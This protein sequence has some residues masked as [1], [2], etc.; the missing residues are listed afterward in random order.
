M[1]II[2][3]ISILISLIFAPLGCVNLWKKYTYFGDGL[4]HA[5]LLAGSI[6]IIG[7]IP[8]IYSGLLLAI[9]FAVSVFKLKSTS[10]SN[11][12]ISMISSFML[13]IAF[14]LASTTTSQVNIDHLLF[15]DIVS[16]SVDDLKMLGLLL[17]VVGCFYIIFYKRILL[18][19]LNRDIAQVQGINVKMIELLFL[20]IL[21]LAVFLTIKIVGALLVTSI[22]LIPAIAARIIST[23][24][25]QMIIISVGLALISNLLGLYISL[26]LDIPTMP[27]IIVVN[28]MIY[29]L[30]NIFKIFQHR[31][32]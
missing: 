32:E 8:I 16:A 12:V 4:A 21:S 5:S 23:T 31:L 30:L 25:L 18:I 10:E 13:A 24:P 9:I 17:V 26:Y 15:G 14:I 19:V 28:V 20:I 1:L 27:I 22:L 6:S 11:A 3:L 29:F 2:I 7:N